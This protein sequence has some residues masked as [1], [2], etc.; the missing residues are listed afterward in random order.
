MQIILKYDPNLGSSMISAFRF[1]FIW[2]I[3]FILYIIASAAVINLRQV[4]SL[5]ALKVSIYFVAGVETILAAVIK[6]SPIIAIVNLWS[7]KPFHYLL[8]K[9]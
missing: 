9:K 7:N 4:F 5:E 1:N 3:I 8:T 6:I 2:R